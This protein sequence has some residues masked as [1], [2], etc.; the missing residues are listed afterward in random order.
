MSSLAQIAERM[1]MAAKAGVLVVTGDTKVVEKGHGDGC[2]INTAGIGVM[3]EGLIL[4]R[5]ALDPGDAVIVSGSIGDHGMAI[6][7]VRESLEFETTI[8][9][10]SRR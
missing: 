1:R 3:P 5:P 10:D 8:E 4:A 2:Y 6:M 7:S 9:S